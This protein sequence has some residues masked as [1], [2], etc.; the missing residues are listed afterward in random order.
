[1]N[2]S[3]GVVVHDLYKGFGDQPVL[4]G[5][6]LSVPAGTFTA[7]LGTSGSG[8]TTLL[9]IIAGYER[10][11]RGTVAIGTALLDDDRV[12]VRPE[13]RHI[14]YVSQE[15]TLF[16]HLSV[17]ANIGFGLARRQR[18]SSQV[19][20]LL[21]AVGL[22]GLGERYP[23]QLSGGQQQRVALARSLAVGARVVLLDEP[24]N[25]LDANLRS[26]V[27]SDVH[28]ILREAGAT[29]I[30][31]THDQDE[32]LSMADLI[33]V[34]RHG[35]IAQLAAPGAIYDNPVDAD[36]AHFLGDANLTTGTATGQAVETAFGLLP[37]R[38]N[39]LPAPKGQVCVMF[40]PEQVDLVEGGQGP[41]VP[42]RVLTAEFHGSDTVVCVAPEA[43]GLEAPI[44]ARVLG[45]L[46]SLTGSTVSITVRG[47]VCA[48]PV[49][50]SDPGT[51]PAADPVTP[52]VHQPI[53]NMT[54]TG[55]AEHA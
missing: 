52:S 6:H 41:G 11:D 27:R 32:A 28:D 55:H 26:S 47:S 20:D 2:T 54:G 9:R 21:D 37:I 10:P 45:N 53:D 1:M 5:L 43:R 8:K 13:K 46:S 29:G 42:A 44:V 35:A 40:R 16:P 48:W 38:D 23:H 31:V 33:A 14:G 4:K 50:P 36:L 19:G 34:I 24:F 25:T 3:S 30:L 7:V 12:H 49:A 22:N 39:P 51:E 17:A 18:R 15:G